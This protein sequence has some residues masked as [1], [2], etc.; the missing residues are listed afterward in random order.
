M[1]DIKIG[2]K[3]TIFEIGFIASTVKREIEITRKMNERLVF[4]IKGKR[5]EFYLPDLTKCLVF[6]GHNL[7][8]ISDSEIERSSGN[9]VFAGNA[10]IN[11]GSRDGGAIDIIKQFILDNALSPSNEILSKIVFVDR[12]DSETIIFPELYKGGH[13]VVDRILSK[14]DERRNQN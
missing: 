1:Q 10:C 9:V 13:A 4:R 12:D 11:V 3:L 6:V 14:Q 5:K 7:P 8:I 2:N